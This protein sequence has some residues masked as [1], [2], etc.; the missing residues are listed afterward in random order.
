MPPAVRFEGVLEPGLDLFVLSVE[1]RGSAVLCCFS[2]YGCELDFKCF[3]LVTEI[4]A[5]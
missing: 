1:V 2:V 4:G 5:R 3:G